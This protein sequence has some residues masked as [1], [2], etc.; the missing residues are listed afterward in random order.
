VSRRFRKINACQRGFASDI[1]R[2]VKRWIVAWCW[3]LLPLAA[4]SYPRYAFVDLPTAIVHGDPGRTTVSFGVSEAGCRASIARTVASRLEISATVSEERLFDLGAR[5]VLIEDL[6]PL[7]VATAAAAGRLSLLS[8]LLLG[9]VH[10]NLGRTWGDDNARW[11][12][13]ELSPHP[14]LSLLVGLEGR[15]GRAGAVA[16]IRWYPGRTGLWGLS[17]LIRRAGAEIRV[18]GTM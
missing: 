12:T 5:V 18:G 9:P 2:N 7:S 11:A 13:L 10:V 17:L 4:F 8:T 1:L 16:A 3:L 6:G 15:T 14:R